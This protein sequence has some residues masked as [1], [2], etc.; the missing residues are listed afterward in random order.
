MEIAA[1]PTTSEVQPLIQVVGPRGYPAF[2]DGWERV[3]RKKRQ[4]WSVATW[5]AS[6]P[7]GELGAL[8]LPVSAGRVGPAL[9]K[10]PKALSEPVFLAGRTLEAD[11]PDDLALATVAH[12]IKHVAAPRLI[13]APPVVELINLGR[14]DRRWAVDFGV[15]WSLPVADG[16]A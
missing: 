3:W 8:L 16:L 14:V 7:D 6:L 2:R 13:A 11:G 1:A 9:G 15:T 10:H 4:P 5:P 12:W